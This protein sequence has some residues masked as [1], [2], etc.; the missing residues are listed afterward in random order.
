MTFPRPVKNMNAPKQQTFGGKSQRIRW[1]SICWPKQKY[2]KG[3]GTQLFEYNF[4]LFLNFYIWNRKEITDTCLVLWIIV[5][6][7]KDVVSMIR[8]H[9]TG[10]KWKNQQNLKGNF[11]VIF[12]IVMW[13]CV[14]T[15]WYMTMWWQ[16][17]TWWYMRA[18]NR[19]NEDIVVYE[20]M[21]VCEETLLY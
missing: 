18:I 3:Y 10:K 8:D 21:V 11:I 9:F 19:C 7:N 6:E 20:D 4:C 13:W 2:E 15:R 12:Y 1:F 16:M 14:R 5:N 17:G